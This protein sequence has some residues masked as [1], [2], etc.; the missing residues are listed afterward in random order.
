MK[1]EEIDALVEMARAFEEM[2]GGP[3]PENVLLLKIA[4]PGYDKV[5]EIWVETAAG[6]KI[7]SGGSQGSGRED[8][9]LKQVEMREPLPKDAVLVVSLFTDKAIVPVPFEMKEVVLP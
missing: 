7:E 6:E 5:Q 4:R 8:A 2:G 3:L 1:D 9:F